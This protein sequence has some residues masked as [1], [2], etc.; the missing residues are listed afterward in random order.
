MLYIEPTRQINFT[1]TTTGSK[2][3]KSQSV[4]KDSDRGA[5][6]GTLSGLAVLG[7]SAIGLKKTSKM[8][9]EEALKKNGVE[10]KDGIATLI[11]SGEKFTGKMQRFEKKKPERKCRIC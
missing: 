7:L 6:L 8:S 2:Q 11:K 1:N 10:I 9:F 3:D 4:Q 5:V